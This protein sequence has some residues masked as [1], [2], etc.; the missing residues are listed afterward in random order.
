MTNLIPHHLLDTANLDRALVETILTRAEQYFIA[1]R[2]EQKHNN[3]LAGKT[4]VNLFFEPSTRTRTSFEIAAKRLGADVINISLEQSSAKKGETPL[5]TAGNLDAM[6]VDAFVIRHAENNMPHQI[7]QHVK[8][9]V[10]NAGDGTN[11]HP[12]Q[13]LLDLLTIRRR[14][15]RIE[16]LTVAICGDVAHS[17]V[18]RS[19]I[20]LL[21]LFGANIRVVAPAALNAGNLPPTVTVIN[22]LEEGLSGADVIMALRIQ[23]ERLS[24]SM[25]PQD[26][27][28][29]IKTFRLNHDKIK[30]AKPDT[31][32]MHPGPI[33]RGVEIT[34]EL[35]D[36]PAYSVIREQVESGV[37]LRM[38][39]LDLLVGK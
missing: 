1:N 2:T 24:Y 7:T 19:N 8:A 23:H 3:H 11:E 31:I 4:V 15:G 39:V 6:N 25:S 16:G 21:S 17:R 27:D 30:L 13:G 34:S 10:I 37:A 12:T 33:N 26:M 38:A 35:A 20:N 18:A 32:V 36:D 9:H 5:D 14:K 29:Y 28:Q 22:N